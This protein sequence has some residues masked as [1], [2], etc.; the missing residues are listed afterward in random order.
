[1]HC[2]QQCVN[3][4]YMYIYI[5][6]YI[7]VYHASLGGDSARRENV[8]GQ[9]NSLIISPHAYDRD[10]AGVGHGNIN[11]T[12][13]LI[14]WLYNKHINNKHINNKHINNMIGAKTGR[15]TEDG[16]AARLFGAS[17]QLRN[18]FSRAF[19]QARSHRCCSL[20]PTPPFP[21]PSLPRG[22][23]GFAPQTRLH[24]VQRC[25]KVPMRLQQEHRGAT[26]E[27][28]GRG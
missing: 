4:I 6:I 23:I 3:V 28:G 15:R 18:D 11:N 8:P 26:G 24:A 25:C 22:A 7:C 27:V 19:V 5:Y 10:N 13:R 17:L 20:L 12:H 2:I 9:A 21:P 16:L 14:I 1:M